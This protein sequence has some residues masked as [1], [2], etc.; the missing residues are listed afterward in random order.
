M[1]LRHIALLL[2]LIGLLTPGLPAKEKASSEDRLDGKVI[3]LARYAKAYVGSGNVTV[4]VAPY[5]TETDEGAI[6]LFKG[7]ESPW[8]G[9]AINH[10]LRYSTYRGQEYV[11]T[12][13]GQEWVSLTISKEQ[14]TYQLDVPGARKIKL[15]PSDGA[16]QLANPRAIFQEYQKQQKSPEASK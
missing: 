2:G 16:A 4:E 8:D 1:K 6:I 9:K 11:T 13:N 7:I 12:H 15:A 5:K 3:E 10:R 14:E